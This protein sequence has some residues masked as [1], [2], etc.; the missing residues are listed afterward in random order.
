MLWPQTV[1]YITVTVYITLKN[2]R[3]KFLEYNKQMQ[4]SKFTQ[5]TQKITESPARIDI[6]VT[7]QFKKNFL[8]TQHAEPTETACRAHYQMWVPHYVT[9]K[10]RSKRL[11]NV[12]NAFIGQ[13]RQGIIALL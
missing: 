2:A 7:T 1:I 4:S 8:E 11:S 6:P 13:K 5:W 3:D 12:V 10:H 9:L